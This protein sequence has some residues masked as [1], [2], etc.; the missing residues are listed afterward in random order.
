[1]SGKARATKT[2][3]ISAFVSMAFAK[4]ARYWKNEK[5]CDFPLNGE[6]K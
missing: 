5:I 2:P 1:M 6:A 4:R 3:P